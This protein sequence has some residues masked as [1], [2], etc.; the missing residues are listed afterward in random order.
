MSAVQTATAAEPIRF[1][2]YH[3]QFVYVANVYRGALGRGPEIRELTNH[4]YTLA[5]QNC[6]ASQAAGLARKIFGSAE[7]SGLGL[8]ATQKVTRAYQAVLSR[9]P[10]QDGLAYFVGRLNQGAAISEVAASMAM[11]PEFADTQ[12]PAFCTFEMVWPHPYEG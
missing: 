10:D 8:N 3:G 1:A 7:F 6:S 2:T 12:L 11:S 9:A 5:G 4:L